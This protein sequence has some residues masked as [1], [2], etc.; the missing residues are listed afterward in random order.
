MPC[1]RNSAPPH[2]SRRTIRRD[3]F[4]KPDG[5]KLIALC[6]E[7]LAELLPLVDQLYY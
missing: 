3:G 7:R 1:H 2:G 6:K 4:N 5:Q